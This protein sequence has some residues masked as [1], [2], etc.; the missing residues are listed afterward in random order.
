MSVP[1][2]MIMLNAFMPVR[3]ERLSVF[4]WVDRLR[5]GPMKKSKSNWVISSTTFTIS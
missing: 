4:I 1:L 3:L 2:Q 5:A